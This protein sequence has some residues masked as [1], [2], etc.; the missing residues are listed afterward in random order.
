MEGNLPKAEIMTQV[1]IEASQQVI[2]FSGMGMLLLVI[3]FSLT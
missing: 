2:E 3:L 1:H